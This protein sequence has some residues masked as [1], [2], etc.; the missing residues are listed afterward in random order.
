MRI[1]H[2]LK[3]LEHFLEKWRLA[4]AQRY[5][6]GGVVIQVD[7]CYLVS[8]RPRSAAD[9]G[10][11]DWLIEARL[12]RL[13]RD[14][15]RRARQVADSASFG[16]GLVAY[17]RAAITIDRHGTGLWLRQPIAA[18]HDCEQFE[19]AFETFCDALELWSSHQTHGTSLPQGIARPLWA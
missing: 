19:S 10:R 4:A 2:R 15:T 9:A 3:A 5:A 8:L 18:P 7:A 11:S 6:D 13:S 12:A 17:A 1:A 14:A 16:L